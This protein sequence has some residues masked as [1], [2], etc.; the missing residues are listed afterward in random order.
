MRGQPAVPCPR[1]PPPRPSP[2][3][4]S[5][6]PSAPTAVK[7]SDTDGSMPRA[8]I[9]RGMLVLTASSSFTFFQGEEKTRVSL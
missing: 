6:L 2:A 1:T 5:G 8:R 3:Q 7:K 9:G 4:R